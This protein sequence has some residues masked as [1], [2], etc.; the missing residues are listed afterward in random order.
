MYSHIIDTK[1]HLGR[2]KRRGKESA[3]RYERSYFAKKRT[4]L[5]REE[6]KN[7]R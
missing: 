1:T 2:M 6:S 5:Q 4:N 7:E 3:R